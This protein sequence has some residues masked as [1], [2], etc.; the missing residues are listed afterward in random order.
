VSNPR[1]NADDAYAVFMGMPQSEWQG[2]CLSL[3]GG[4]VLE[5]AEQ[6]GFERALADRKARES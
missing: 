5:P 6:I 4:G 2:L 1:K 3:F